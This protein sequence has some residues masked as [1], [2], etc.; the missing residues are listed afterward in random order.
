MSGAAAF[1]A[2][3]LDA[4]LT[5]PDFIAPGKFYRFP[6]AGKKARNT[7]GYCKLFDDSAGGVFGDFSTG[8]TGNWR[9]DRADIDPGDWRRQSREVRRQAKESRKQEKHEAANKAALIWNQALPGD[10]HRYLARKNI[11]SHGTRID[12]YDN[13]LVPVYFSRKLVSLQFIAPDGGKRFLRG[14]RVSGGYYPIE[15]DARMVIICEGFATAATLQEETGY[16]T[17]AAFNAGNLKIVAEYARAQHP[18]GDIVIAADMDR[19]TPGNPG[20][21]HASKAA[22]AIN[23]RLAVPEF[24]PHVPGT[25][26][27]DLAAWARGH[28]V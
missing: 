5:P 10:S 11:Q 28:H 15:G 18:N 1:R 12:Q 27:N 13:L 17:L 25:D 7:A 3:M 9:A 16:L 8:L 21:T 22:R 26:F 14:G 6:G 20:L 24:P 23:G 4:D 19:N 2:A